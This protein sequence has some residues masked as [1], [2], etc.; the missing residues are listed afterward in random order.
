MPAS[1]T[2]RA[3]RAPVV[4]LAVAAL[5]LGLAAAATP[6]HATRPFRYTESAVSLPPGGVRLEEGMSRARWD[7]GLKVYAL[8][9][10][11]SYSLYANLDLEVE[12]PWVVAGGGG[13]RFDDGLGD[14]VTKAKI[15]FVKERAAIP[16]TLSGLIGVKFPTGPDNV[17]TDEADV[18]IAALA[19]KVI[20]PAQVH[21][22]L[23]YTFVGDSQSNPAN[24]ALGLAVAVAVQTPVEFLKG[25]GEFVW[26]EAR[27]RGGNDRQEITGGAVYRVAPRVA[28]DA[29]LSFGLNTGSPPQSGA[30]D[31]TFAVGVTWDAGRL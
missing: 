28:L 27:A 26:E 15:N 5:T 13:A 12:A 20:G 10:E 11:V 16:L 6:A 17:S 21:G 31:T 14:V 7:S 30:P 8:E 1:R 22:N 24:D 18:Q 9:T 23:S 4:V 19:S 2:V 29:T 3:R 25:I